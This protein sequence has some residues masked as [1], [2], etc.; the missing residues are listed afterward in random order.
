VNFIYS[1][2]E[3]KN[4]MIWCAMLNGLASIDPHTRNV[5]TFTT[6]DG[7]PFNDLDYAFDIGFSGKIFIGTKNGFVEFDP[8]RQL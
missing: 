4:K 2:V 5:Q 3:G 8:S 1:L 6:V 7:L